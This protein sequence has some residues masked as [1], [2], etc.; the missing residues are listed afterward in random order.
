MVLTC[1]WSG[2]LHEGVCH[3]SFNDHVLARGVS[4]NTSLCKMSVIFFLL[5]NRG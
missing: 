5:E 4:L 2:A 1:T 3:V